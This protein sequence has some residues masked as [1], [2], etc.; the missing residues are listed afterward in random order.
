MNAITRARQAANRLLRTQKSLK[1]T[2]RAIEKA[3]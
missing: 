2:A 3:V 1:K